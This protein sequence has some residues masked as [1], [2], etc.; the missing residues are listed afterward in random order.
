MSKVSLPTI[1]THLR[2]LGYDVERVTEGRDSW[3]LIAG[4]SFVLRPEHDGYHLTGE[5]ALSTYNI[6]RVRMHVDAGSNA[7]STA[8]NVHDAIV[9]RYPEERKALLAR[10][11]RR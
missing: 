1:A 5:V 6:Q 2:A 3:L 4:G 8:A 10:F 7:P 9:N 11:T